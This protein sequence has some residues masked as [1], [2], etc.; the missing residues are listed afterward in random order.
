VCTELLHAIIQTL[1]Y[2]FCL[3]TITMFCYIVNVLFLF[4][5]IMLYM[6]LLADEEN[7][8]IIYEEELKHSARHHCQ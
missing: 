1:F 4:L 7:L 2:A 3:S 5:F 8:F 6:A